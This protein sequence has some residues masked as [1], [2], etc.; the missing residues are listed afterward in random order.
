MIRQTSCSCLDMNLMC[1]NRQLKLILAS[2]SPRRSELL[3]KA[4]V[5]FQ[6]IPAN[7][8]EV[9]P[10]HLTPGELAQLNAR[11]K[12]KQVAHHYPYSLVLGADTVVCLGETVFGKPA[13][14]NESRRFLEALSG[15]KHHV[16]T[17]VSLIC[18]AQKRERLFSVCTEVCFKPLTPDQ[19]TMYISQVNT[20]DKAGA[21]AIQ[22]HGDFIVDHIEG[23]HSNVVGLPMEMLSRELQLWFP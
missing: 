3:T 21:Y 17:G 20:L 23:S 8:D 9:A 6:V 4:G 1:D 16:I 11:N 18:I 12:A 14:L 15:K 7:V 13:D 5:D 19:I 22:E 2:A 10:L